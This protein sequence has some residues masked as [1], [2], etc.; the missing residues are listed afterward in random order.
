MTLRAAPDAVREEQVLTV[1]V[2]AGGNRVGRLASIVNVRDAVELTIMPVAPHGEGQAMV[3]TTLTNRGRGDVSGVVELSSAEARLEPEMFAFEQIPPGDTI[4]QTVMMTATGSPTSVYTVTA[5]ARLENGEIVEASRLVSTYTVRRLTRAPVI[6]GD[7][8][9]WPL[10]EPIVLSGEKDVVL[11]HYPYDGPED[12]SVRIWTGWDAKYFYLA[13]E[14]VD[15]IFS[16]E[17]EGYDIYKSDG[18]EL[19][20]DADFVGDVNERTYSQDDNQYGFFSEKGKP[21]VFSW[22]HLGDVSPGGS[23]AF[24]HEPHQIQ[25]RSGQR[26][27]YIVEGRIPLDELNLRDPRPGKVIGFNV[28]LDDDDTTTT[29]HP[30]GQDLQMSWTKKRGAWQNPQKFGV[31]FFGE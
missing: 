20:F 1:W 31:V 28:A 25:L 9:D 18:L 29:I 23:V 2:M 17:I 26:A 6:D 24:N 19:Y 27:D 14:V 30:F 16:D 13:A 11:R 7:L 12:A 15:D 3:Q 8:S 21:V 4:Q 5:T 22:S 10:T